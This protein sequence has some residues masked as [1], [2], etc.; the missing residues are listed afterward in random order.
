[1]A[2]LKQRLHKKNSSGSYD[3]I[4][5]ETSA[6]LVLMSDGTTVEAAVNGKAASSHTHSGY[7]ASSHNHAA[8]DIT[9]GT[10]PLTRGGTGVTSISAL[11]TAL[12]I[13]G[14]SSSSGLPE[15]YY[16]Y[17]R[18]SANA[19]WTINIGKCG[20]IL[21]F[22]DRLLGYDGVPGITGRIIK[23]GESTNVAVANGDEV[24]C[25]VSLNSTGTTV[26][27]SGASDGPPYCELYF[28]T[29]SKYVTNT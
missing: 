14:S 28:M 9:S 8:G 21:I 12:G 5:L 25:N 1:M 7:A 17:S 26:T 27:V 29:L 23:A 19:N 6:G 22:N 24:S 13:S 2:T 10:L 16:Y 20:A 3:I 18:E 11:K 4:H 15:M